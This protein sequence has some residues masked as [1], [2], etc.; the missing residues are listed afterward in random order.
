M[1]RSG[2]VDEKVAAGHLCIDFN[3]FFLSLPPSLP[4]SLS[5]CTL[6]RGPPRPRR[7]CLKGEGE[8]GGE[9]EGRAT[10]G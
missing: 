6:P 4:P 7:S 9:E 8:E 1:N 2:G 5:P 3:L 10:P